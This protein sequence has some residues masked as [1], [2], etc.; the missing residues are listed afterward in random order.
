MLL[1]WD[2]L[3]K[4]PHLQDLHTVMRNPQTALLMLL[5]PLFGWLN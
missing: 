3:L 5:R 1:L 2:L 4:C